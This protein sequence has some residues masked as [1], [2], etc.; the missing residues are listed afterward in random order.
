M[1][2]SDYFVQLARAKG[3][4]VYA[5][6]GP[7]NIQM[8]K[9]LGAEKVIDY[10]NENL[11]SA[12]LGIEVDL[13]FDAVGS[14]VDR[15]QSFLLV[16]R[17][18]RVV[19]V[20][21][22]SDEESEPHTTAPGL[23]SI[24]RTVSDIVWKN[25]YNYMSKGVTYKPVMIPDYLGEMLEEITKFVERGELKTVIDS[26]FSLDDIRLAHQRS[27]SGRAKGKI[28]VQHFSETQEHQP[29]TA[30]VI[31]SKDEDEE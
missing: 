19:T 20:Q 11:L 3:A 25:A 27:E 18:G 5:T 24:F 23:G 8:V 17:N 22:Q 30:F 15:D 29:S 10:R 4:T 9:D 6:C 21:P 16:K 28:V 26:T 31:T 1:Y 7:D 14:K 13:V 2:V 12:L